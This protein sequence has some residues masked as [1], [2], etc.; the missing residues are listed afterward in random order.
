MSSI[1]T[2]YSY[3]NGFKSGDFHHA[4]L[5]ISGNIHT[6]YLDG[7]A[8]Q[9]NNSGTDVLTTLGSITQTVIGANSIFNQAFR[10]II[11]DVRVYNQAITATQVSNLYMNRNLIAYYPF[12]TSVNTLTPNYATLQYDAS[13]VGSPNLTPGFVGTSALQ[14]ANSNAVGVKATQ[15]VIASPGNQTF[16]STNGLTISCWVNFNSSTNT[17]KIMRI[18]NIDLITTRVGVDISG[19]Y[20]IYNYIT[21]KRVIDTLS[22]GAYNAMV[23]QGTKLQAGA[24]GCKLLLSSAINNPIIQIKAGTGGTPTDFYAVI[25]GTTTILQNRSGQTVSAFLGGLTGYVTKWYDQTGNGNHAIGGTILPTLNTTSN[26]VDFGASTGLYGYFNLPDNSYPT[27]NLP[28]TYVYNQGT[29]Y[30]PGYFYTFRGGSEDNRISY[31]SSIPGNNTYTFNHQWTKSTYAVGDVNPTQNA[32][33]TITG[34]GG[35]NNSNVAVYSNNTSILLEKTGSGV[36]NQDG[37]YNF[38]G[39]YDDT[40]SYPYKSTMSFFYWLPY[41][42]NSSD[43]VILGNTLSTT[44]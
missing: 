37:S 16:D 36:R 28:Y 21:Q 41:Q 35:S 38:L 10:G 42:L 32:V 24:Y 20:M 30:S 5:S 43:R 15:Y 39:G 40:G 23:Y 11:G 18:F 22:T 33:L 6:L 19:T 2:S 9:V 29:V 4:V 13:M 1:T 27:G 31:N 7:S 44:F 25:S 12:D 34:N 14:I 26:V 17:S 3:N 8:V